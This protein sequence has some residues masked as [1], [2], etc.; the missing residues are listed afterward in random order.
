MIALLCPINLSNSKNYPAGYPLGPFN[1][2]TSILTYIL[3]RFATTRPAVIKRSF[4]S[5]IACLTSRWISPTLAELA[6][7]PKS[8]KHYGLKLL[9]FSYTVVIDR[10]AKKADVTEGAMLDTDWR[11]NAYIY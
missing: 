9:N 6:I 2:S 8:R 5:A 4:L 11:A 3:L 10:V 7:L 1:L